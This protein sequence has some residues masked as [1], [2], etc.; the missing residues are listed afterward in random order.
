MSTET[1]RLRYLAKSAAGVPRDLVQSAVSRVTAI[2]PTVLIFN[3]TWVCD[4]RCEM[5][6]NWKWGNRKEDLTL[7]EIDKA[8]TGDILERRREPE[9]LGRRA[10]DPQR[11]ARD[12]RDSSTAGCRACEKSVSTRRG[13]RRSARSPCSRGSWSSR[14]ARD[15]LLS[16][17]VSIDGIGD[18]H[19]QVRNVK[20]GF[21]KALHTIEAM[22]ALAAQLRRLPVR[23][24]LHDLRDESRRRR[25]HPRV[26]A[27]EASR[28]R[29]Q[30][31]AV[32]RQH[33]SQ[34]RS[35][36]DDRV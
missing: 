21:D 32:H 13:S 7:D 2:K 28:H 29:V 35:R 26:G 33:A 16:V 34:P 31:A 12:G 9:Y 10:D 20:S 22:Q 25:E 30:H 36:S 19:D 1:F 17:R 27:F 18:V 24:G 4:A 14:G 11:P 6:N 5:C 23:S 8:M 3:C 15:L